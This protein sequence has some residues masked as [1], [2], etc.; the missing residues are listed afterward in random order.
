MITGLRKS[1]ELVYEPFASYY[2]HFRT[3]AFDSTRWLLIGYGAKDMH[4]NQVLKV[5]LSFHSRNHSDSFSCIVVNHIEDDSK[6]E[7]SWY[8]ADDWLLPI[9]G[10]DA[11]DYKSDACN[12]PFRK[13]ALNSFDDENRI[14]IAVDGTDEFIKSLLSVAKSFLLR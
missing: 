11:E 14:R 8:A 3:T 4:I 10:W 9:F 7:N 5:A 6:S 1:E 13:G 2:H 12:R